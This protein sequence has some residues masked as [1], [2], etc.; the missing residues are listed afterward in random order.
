MS[1]IIVVSLISIMG[2]TP[3]AYVSI[4]GTCI[5]LVLCC[6]LYVLISSAFRITGYNIPEIDSLVVVRYNTNIEISDFLF[7][8]ILTASLGAVMDVSV[9]VATSVAELRETNP[10]LGF[11]DL[12]RSG[13]RIGRDIIGSTANTLIMAIVGSSLTTFIMFRI[14]KYQ[15]NLL[16]N[17][18]DIAIEILKTIT[19]SAALILCAP[20]TAYIAARIYGRMSVVTESVSDTGSGGES[21]GRTSGGKALG[22]KASSGKASSGSKASSSNKASS[23][24]KSSGSKTN[25][26]ASRKKPQSKNR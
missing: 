26:A 10:A 21:G 20:V 23:G 1:C 22:N 19:S 18:D 13:L 11:E 6:M 17:D 16:I 14:Y 3:K 8:G 12:F 4:L 24:N 2:F 25:A 7:A 5:G 9:S 15:Y